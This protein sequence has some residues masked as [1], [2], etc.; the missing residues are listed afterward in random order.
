M[1]NLFTYFAISMITLTSSSFAQTPEEKGFEIAARSDRSDIGFESSE[2][3]MKMILRNAGGDESVRTLRTMTLEKENEQVGDKS[4]TIFDKP[5]DIK[6]TAL[7]SYA[8]I[9]EPDDQWLYLPALKRVK[10][11]SSANKSGPFVGSEFAFED[12]TSS[13]L[14]KYTYKYVKEDT[15]DGMKV[16]VIERFPRYENSGYQKQVSYIDQKDFQVRK[17]D[18]FDRKGDLLK[19]LLFKNYT[20]YND[21]FF[22]AGKLEMTNHQNGKST[23]LI[24]SDYRFNIGLKDKDF[25]KSRLKNV[26]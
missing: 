24:Y 20:K 23:D 12:F 1:K 15:L 4:F 9:L 8:K 16:D 2:V 18:F 11:I 19:T 14:N 13:E 25:V 3:D 5:R 6:G 22:R 10:R 17:I 7:L 21:K 26:R